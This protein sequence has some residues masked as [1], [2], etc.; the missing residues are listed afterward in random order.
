MPRDATIRNSNP[1][2]CQI[3]PS[4]TAPTNNCGDNNENEINDTCS[5]IVNISFLRNS[6]ELWEVNPLMSRPVM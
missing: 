6:K 5:N 4:K 2:S 3:K 1:I